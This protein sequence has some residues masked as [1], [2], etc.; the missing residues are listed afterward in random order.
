M[1]KYTIEVPDGSVTESKSGDSILLVAISAL[2]KQI[3]KSVNY[4]YDGYADGNPVYDQ[5]EC[6]SC[7]HI[8]DDTDDSWLEPFCP[9]CGQALNW[10]NE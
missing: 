8:W 5:A 10:E 7:G 2:E 9:H 1:E 6:P 3:P 4:I